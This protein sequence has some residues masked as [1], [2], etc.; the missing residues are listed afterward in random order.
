ME[1]QDDYFQRIQ[2]A[3]LSR[4]RLLYGTAASAGG[5]PQ[6]SVA[7]VGRRSSPGQAAEHR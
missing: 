6:P 2:R 4:R 5:W 3:R 7:A 1:E